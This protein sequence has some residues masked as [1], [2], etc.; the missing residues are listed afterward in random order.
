MPSYARK[1]GAE[2]VIK[3]NRGDPRVK[4]FC[5]SG[6]YSGVEDVE[7]YSE[8]IKEH[9]QDIDY[10]VN[11]DVMGKAKESF[12]NYRRMRRKG[13]D[14]RAAWHAGTDTKYLEIYLRDSNHICIGLLADKSNK[15][16]IENLDEIWSKYLVDGHGYPKYRV[17]AL[18]VG[19]L[20]ILRRYPWYSADS[21]R[22]V[23]ESGRLACI[24]IP[25][26]RDGKWIFDENPIMIKV[27]VRGEI[28]PKQILKLP[29][30][31][32][33]MIKR[34]LKELGF[35]C[36]L[37]TY[38]DGQ[39]VDVIDGLYNMQE[40]RD[41]VNVYFFLRFVQSLPKWPWPFRLR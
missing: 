13:L 19:S 15:E 21:T 31:E 17:H 8:F 2:T 34:Y 29:R 14:P 27:G 35:K 3:V 30:P 7:G 6:A 23:K 36:G 25:K 37:F 38:K 5:D 26:C 4:I 11:V 28:T 24:R 32:Q 12:D 39:R 1:K 10:Y 22:W 20:E 33:E 18:G 9:E 16:R 41:R 40:L